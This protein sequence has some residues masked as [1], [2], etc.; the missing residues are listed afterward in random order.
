MNDK[1]LRFE[2]IA[3]KRMTETIKKMRLL[4]NL[5]NKHNYDY[6]EAHVKQIIDTLENELRLLKSRFKEGTASE[7][8]TFEFKK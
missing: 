2:R 3:E 8:Y 7:N 6:T 1:R 4:G 5:S